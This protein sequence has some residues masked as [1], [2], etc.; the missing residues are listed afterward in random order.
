MPSTSTFQ[1]RPTAYKLKCF[2]FSFS[3]HFA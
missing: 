2:C 1:H 3:K